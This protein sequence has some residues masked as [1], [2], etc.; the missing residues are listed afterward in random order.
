MANFDRNY[1]TAQTGTG[2]GVEAYDEGL[3][4]YMLNVY[5]Y[6]G[7]GIAFTAVVVLG[8]MTYAPQVI[9]FFGTGWMRFVPFVGILALGFMAPRMIFSGNTAVGHL[10]YWSY[11]ALWGLMMSPIIYILYKTGQEVSIY[12]AFGITAATFGA[13]SLFGYT[14]KKNLGAFATFFVMGSIGLLIAIILNALVFQSGMMS[15]IIS[16]AVVLLFSGITAWE[17]QEIKQMYYEG[18]GPKT[19]NGKAIFGAFLLYGSFATMF[20]HILNLVMSFSSD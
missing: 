19:M 18:D 3:R 1:A 20:I 10:A 13:M 14:T 5:N 11:C 4:K 15:I 7:L 12:R 9:T 6:M 8:L 16:A 17:T 2:V